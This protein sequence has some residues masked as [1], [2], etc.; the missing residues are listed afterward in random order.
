MTEENN[1][2]ENF[3]DVEET[4]SPV[5]KKHKKSFFAKLAGVVPVFSASLA[6]HLILLL[7]ISLIPGNEIPDEEEVVIITQFEETVEEEEEI[8]EIEEPLV[9]AEEVEITEEIVTEDVVEEEVVE[10]EEA[11]EVDDAEP[12]DEIVDFV[13]PSLDS[14]LN[15][16]IMGFAGIPAGAASAS[17]MLAGRFST[18]GKRM[19]SGAKNFKIVTEAL[20]WLAKQ[21]DSG[22]RW[23]SEGHTNAIQG[24]CALA[25]LGN[26]NSTR[27]GRYKDVVKK[28]VDRYLKAEPDDSGHGNHGHAT[29][30]VVMAMCDAYAMDHRHQELKAYC[31]R[32][33]GYV[34]KTQLENGG[35][36][37]G[38]TSA[39]KA[40]QEVDVAQSSW[41]V[42]AL[43]SAKFAGIDFPEESLTKARKLFGSLAAGTFKGKIKVTSHGGQDDFFD[44]PHS[45]SSYAMSI[46][47]F[48]GI[49]PSDGLVKKQAADIFSSMPTKGKRNYWLLYN[50][51]LGLFQ[52]GD[53]SKYWATFKDK[54]ITD[55]RN[56]VKIT[57][58][59][60]YWDNKK[61]YTGK[62]GKSDTGASPRYWGDCGAT[63]M[64]VLNLQ[65][66]Y[67][68]SDIQDAY[69]GL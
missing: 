24:A 56:E 67:R 25:F 3:D 38:G 26:G 31:E 58:E 32:A 66:F 22:G 51:G 6:L 30:F 61:L 2:L 46:L 64:G 69:S 11:E 37:G 14:S 17:G 27:S 33:V 52:M 68:Y 10:I 18:S 5:E 59:G 4:E 63:A 48:L 57:K 19:A 43:V 8:E 45:V 35:W 7:I 55:I 15:P 12:L 1:E 65:V 9:V 34:C 54:I 49:R 29:P 42:M 16:A 23:P 41:F 50:Q 62:T 28:F 39:E 60:V 47:I 53:K 40:A 44:R 20:K 36:S 13:M 21:Q